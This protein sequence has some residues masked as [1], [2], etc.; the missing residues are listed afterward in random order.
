[1]L[2]FISFGLFK[3]VWG[4]LQLLPSLQST[5]FPVTDY[6][7]IYLFCIWPN[8]HDFI[9]RIIETIDVILIWEGLGR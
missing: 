6:R 2:N 4:S 7:I 1:M 9:D 5:E 3:K 8:F